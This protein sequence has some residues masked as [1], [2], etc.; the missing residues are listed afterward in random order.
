MGNVTVQYGLGTQLVEITSNGSNDTIRLFGHGGQGLGWEQAFHI[1]DSNLTFV[2][3]TND[4]DANSMIPHFL[5]YSEMLC[6]LM[7]SLVA[8]PCGVGIEEVPYLMSKVYPNP[9]YDQIHI[10]FDDSEEVELLEVYNIQ[11]AIQIQ[12]P[13]P[14][15]GMS[16]NTYELA[17][18]MY[19]IKIKGAK[20]QSI[21]KWVKE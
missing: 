13:N 11:G 12:I 7:N 1:I 15:S 2:L 4:F 10:E 6:E 14:I 20:G 3:T 16:V 5:L 9:G 8:N 19:F 21:T 17:T 18:G